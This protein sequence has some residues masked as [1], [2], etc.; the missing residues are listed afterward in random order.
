MTHLE[1]PNNVQRNELRVSKHC[2]NNERTQCGSKQWRSNFWNIH[3]L[4]NLGRREKFK[5]DGFRAKNSSND[6]KNPNS[7]HTFLVPYKSTHPNIRSLMKYASS[8]ELKN[9]P[10]WPQVLYETVQSVQGK[11]SKHVNS[12]QYQKPQTSK[13]HHNC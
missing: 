2:K 9:G 7:L 12:S 10:K 8:D 3:L 5:I 13:D 4:E 1:C 6:P 11:S